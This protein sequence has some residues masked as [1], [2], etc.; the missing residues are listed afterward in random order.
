M[1]RVGYACL[2]IGVAGTRLKTLQKK[3]A[4]EET[5]VSVIRSN[6][7]ALERMICYN[8]EMGIELFRISSDIIPFG[9]SPVNN[10]PWWDIFAPELE[11]IG[12][13]IK[14]RMRVSMHPGQYTV[15]NS[16][17]EDVVLSAIADLEY[18][19]RF[20][21]CLGTGTDS[22]IV[23]HIG[24]IYNDKYL[25]MQR[26][27]HVWRQLDSGIRQRLVIENDERLYNIADALQISDI[28]G[29]PV[30]FDNLHHRLNQPVQA[31]PDADWID[32]CARTW[33]KA[34]GRQ[35]IHYSQQ[36][37]GKKPGAHAD[38]I[39]PALF[40]QEIRHYR[41]EPDIMLE[42]KDKNLSAVK[43]KNLINT[44]GRIEDLE[45]EWQRYKYETLE[46]SPAVYLRIRELLKCKTS[47]PVI[48]FYSLLAQAAQAQENTGYAINAALHVWGYFK[49]IA[50]EQEKAQFQLKLSRFES[51]SLTI[52]A[53]KLFLWRL[54]GKYNREYLLNSLYLSRIG[55]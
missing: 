5:L 45:K 55:E 41:Q 50:S 36:A 30:V 20:L 39:D 9:S 10:L 22:K 2:T 28:T 24:G 25:A 51:G 40:L 1:M 14:P 17:R 35:K 27:C 48:E 13:M 8:L 15:L 31:R 3:N 7:A 54:A 12:R 47:Y 32:L 34:D 43:C 52:R 16:L 4:G 33:Q 49:K 53:L 19:V 11:N 6:L 38:T 44:R 46:K 23:L 42:V 21:D 26:F 18:H 37:A 29:I